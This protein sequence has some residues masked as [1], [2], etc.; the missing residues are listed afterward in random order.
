VR[1]TVASWNLKDGGLDH[2]DDARLRRQL[3]VMA[4]RGDVDVWL[5]QE[6]KGWSAR[7]NL[8]L[9]R[10]ADR[11]Q[12]PARFLI[13]SGHH[14]CDLAML[15]RERPGLR[16]VQER[17]DRA[18][19]WWHALGHLEL[20]VDGI[21]LHVLNVHLAPSAPSLREAEAEVF[22]LFRTWRVIAGG[23]F[24]ALPATGPVPD[25]AAIPES[26]KVHR[27]LDQRAANAIQ[28]AGFHDV[29][30]HLDNDTPTVG[31]RTPGALAYRC[32]RITS[33]LPPATYDTYEVLTLQQPPYALDDPVLSDHC[34]VIAT[35]TID[36]AV[37]YPDGLQWRSPSSTS[38][39]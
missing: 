38:P 27:K 22:G 14:G 17:H 16:V 31:H 5:L 6:A 24:N 13:P 15:V 10:A 4:G 35:F 23:D 30:A 36:A 33:T 12:M 7:G 3:D 37:A 19:P 18:A 28:A 32:D 21:D 20:E 9:H 8:L 25:L 1:L 34:P 26:D 11:L 2:G 29:G 39:D